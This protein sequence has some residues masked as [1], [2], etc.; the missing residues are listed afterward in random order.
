[1]YLIDCID[2]KRE[3]SYYYYFY[4]KTFETVLTWL[5]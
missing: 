2:T 5:E 3:K 4:Y 1:M